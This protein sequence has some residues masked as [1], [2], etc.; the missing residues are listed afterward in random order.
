MELLSVSKQGW[1]GCAAGAALGHAA[2]EILL[3]QGRAAKALGEVAKGMRESANL[4]LGYI[5]N[6]SLIW[7]KES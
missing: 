1:E 2:S 6:S 5:G 7:I 3:A 4:L